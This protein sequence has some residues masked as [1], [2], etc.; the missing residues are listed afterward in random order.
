MKI[1]NLDIPIN[2]KTLLWGGTAVA[3]IAALFYIRSQTTESDATS[4][5]VGITGY[6]PGSLI[7]DN[8]G[9]LVPGITGDNVSNDVSEQVIY[10]MMQKQIEAERDAQAASS[11]SELFQYFLSKLG[12]NWKTAFELFFNTPWGTQFEF[13]FS[14]NNGETPG[15][16]NPPS[17]T[18]GLT[19]YWEGITGSYGQGNKSLDNAANYAGMNYADP[20]LENIGNALRNAIGIV[21][22]PIGF[23]VETLV[24]QVFDVPQLGIQDA[25]AGQPNLSNAN[26][27]ATASA[28]NVKAASASDIAKSANS[29]DAGGKGVKGLDRANA[30]A[31]A[32]ANLSARD[33]ASARASAEAA[34]GKDRGGRSGNQ[35]GGHGRAVGKDG[36]IA[37]GI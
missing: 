7:F 21:G 13:V 19:R 16:V 30:S 26:R 10:D 3:G 32:S 31:N 6:L 37:G 11:A 20:T 33:I 17:N 2:R 25:G 5:D 8:S 14:P 27:S 35:S 4:G 18:S 23:A 9:A 1:G 12:S 15:I 36:R 28:S 22:N 34:L 24:G 29:G